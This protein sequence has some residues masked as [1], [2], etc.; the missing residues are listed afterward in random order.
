M[1]MS[2]HWKVVG[3]YF[4]ESEE[5]RK[6][7]RDI[8]LTKYLEEADDNIQEAIALMW[9]RL[10]EAEYQESYEECAILKDI[11]HRLGE[12]TTDIPR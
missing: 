10:S 3:L 12:D 7:F 6:E 5:I 2:K 9:F 8:M 4:S 1:I 11:L